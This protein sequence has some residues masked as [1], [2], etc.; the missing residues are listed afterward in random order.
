[1]SLSA[2]AS[3]SELLLI[4]APVPADKLFEQKKLSHNVPRKADARTKTAVQSNKERELMPFLDLRSEG[5]KKVRKLQL[6]A[7]GE[8]STVYLPHDR[9]GNSDY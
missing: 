5:E 4:A 2:T 9:G 3:K 1:M 8:F 7:L 6:C